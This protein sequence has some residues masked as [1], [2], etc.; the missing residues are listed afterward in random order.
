M[1]NVVFDVG[2][3]AREPALRAV[4]PILSAAGA[5]MSDLARWADRSGLERHER[6]EISGDEFLDGIVAAAMLRSTARNCRVR[7]LDM[8]EQATRCATSLAR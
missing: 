4:C 8:F 2:W 3:R 1:K 6:G 7:W 5:D